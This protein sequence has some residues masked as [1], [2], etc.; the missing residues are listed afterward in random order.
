MTDEIQNEEAVTAEEVIVKRGRKP[1]SDD[2]EVPVK[3]AMF[4][5]KLIRNYRPIGQFTIGGEAP[6]VEGRL[7]VFAGASIE[8]EI[9]EAKA[10]MASGIAVRNDPISA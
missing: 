1:K 4:P 6:S 9:D 7:K 3:T 5:V 10:M 8:I 2:G